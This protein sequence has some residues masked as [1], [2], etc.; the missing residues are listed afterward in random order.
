MAT[1]EEDI[2]LSEPKG[3]TGTDAQQLECSTESQVNISHMMW[4]IGAKLRSSAE[5]HTQSLSHLCSPSTPFLTF[6]S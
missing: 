3:Q 2:I 1:A 5:Q 4:V 6:K